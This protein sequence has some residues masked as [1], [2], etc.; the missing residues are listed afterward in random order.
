MTSKNLS[1][2][3]AYYHAMNNKKIDEMAQYLAPEVQLISPLSELSG[4][5]AV[6]E[7]AQRL[8][9]VFNRIDIRAK[10]SNDDQVML[11]LNMDCP[12]PIE[13][14]RTAVLQSFEN[15]L[16]TRIELFLDPRPLVK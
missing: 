3:I 7:A 12:A 1:Q 10:F 4:K 11:A 16:I 9:Q 6:L 8:F 2:A 13:T 14:L 5:A 15:N